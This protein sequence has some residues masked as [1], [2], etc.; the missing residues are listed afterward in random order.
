MPLF[1][2]AIAPAYDNIA[3][4]ETNSFTEILYSINVGEDRYLIHFNA[5]TT[6]SIA[7]PLIIVES[8]LN[9]IG[10]MVRWN[11]TR[12]FWTIPALMAAKF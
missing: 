12:N 10:L 7:S 11:H 9:M 4:A 1:M 8:E 2:V 5:C 6:E 3:F